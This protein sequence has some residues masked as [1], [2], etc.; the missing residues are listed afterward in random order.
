[1]QKIQ[2]AF[3]AKKALELLLVFVGNLISAVGVGGF[4]LPASLMMGGATGFGLAASHYF[5]LPVSAFVAV[6]NLLMSTVG[7]CALGGPF[8]LPTLLSTFLY[9][10][11]LSTVVRLLPRPFT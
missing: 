1:M 9:P 10:T 8:A 5:G 11:M 3:S 6:Y 7:A 4:V 2:K